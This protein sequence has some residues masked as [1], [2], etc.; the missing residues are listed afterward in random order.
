MSPQKPMVFR[1]SK[2]ILVTTALTL[3]L[4]GAQASSACAQSGAQTG[5]EASRTVEL[6]SGGKVLQISAPRADIVRVRE[7]VGALGEDASWAVSPTL[8][9]QLV[10]L[11][12]SH[13]GGKTI[14]STGA[15]TVTI[16]DTSLNVDVARPNGDAVLDDT[17]TP[18]VTFADGGGFRLQKRL[19]ADEHIFGLGDKTGPLDRRDR[20]FTFWNTDHFD[21][22]DSDDPIYKSVPF[23]LSVNEKGQAYGFFLDDTF[24][25]FF[26]FGK[27]EP[28]RFEAGADGGSV[29]YYVMAGP[30]PKDVVGAYTYLTG[31]APLA[32]RWALGFQQSHWSY[33]D[34][35]T[36][37]GIVKH[38][39]DDHVPL[40]AIYL[41]ID[42]Q[43][44]NRPFTVNIQAFPNLGGLVSDL[45]AQGVHVV[46]ITDLHIADVPGGGYAPYAEGEKQGYFVKKPGGGDYVGEVWPGPAVFPDFSRKVVRQWWGSLY[47]SFAS[48]GVSGFWNDMNEPA[49]FNVPSKTMPL[50]VV[51]TIDEPGFVPRTATHAEMHNVFGMLNSEATY[52]GIEALQPNA[53]PFVLTRASYAGGQRYAATW[54][55]DNASSWAHLQLSVAQLTNLG[56]SGFAYAGDDIGGFAGDPPSAELLTRWFE[57]G[58]FNPIFRDHYTK[59]KPA[60]EIWVSGPEQEAIRRTYVE[61]RYRLMP[62]LY[63]LAEETSRT[64]LPIMRPVFLDFPQVVD[65]SDHLGGTE[66]D[67]MVGD[68]LLV[69]P[70]PTLESPAP[71][72]VKLPGEGWYDYWSGRRL[73]GASVTETPDIARLPVFVR[74]GAVLFKQPLT[75]S[76]DEVPSG[77]LTLDIYP[78]SDGEAGLYTDDGQSLDYRKGVFFRRKVTLSGTAGTI[79]LMLSATEGDHRPWWS[80]YQVVVHGVGQVSQVSIDGHSVPVEFNAQAQ[81]LTFTLAA[82]S[83][84]QTIAILPA[85]T[86]TR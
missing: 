33:P 30:A 61:E 12:V 22:G 40:D 13:A 9:A 23:Y 78:G 80:A 41:D 51:H 2:T 83:H 68:D 74:P 47:T 55:G 69:A 32:P 28:G 81:T 86:S 8:R 76:T 5:A 35:A 19:A 44:H 58:A 27:A 20:A 60:Q 25:S 49:I 17:T 16:D 66:F 54:T 57:I 37:R 48:M 63:S 39:K 31:K 67:F 6:K 77:P 11:S 50:D 82:V 36:V 72:E 64:G 7:G 45:K 15:V 71:Y 38:M 34:E 3:C 79:R 18:A 46:L 84:A 4:S 75:Q 21:Y 14:V 85:K 62:T 24:R 73:A 26:D 70:A 43:D 10:P 1:V 42:Y 56:L 53:R 52:Q 65:G 59:G 29:D